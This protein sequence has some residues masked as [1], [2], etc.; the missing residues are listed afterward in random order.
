MNVIVIGG[1]PG[2]G[3]S[4]LVRNF[5]QTLG[6]SQEMVKWTLPELSRLGSVIGKEFASSRVIVLG[7]Y[8]DPEHRFPGTDRMSRS[9][10]PVIQAWFEAHKAR[11][12][13]Y[14]VIAEGQRTFTT[15]FVDMAVNMGARVTVV[16]VVA[17]PLEIQKRMRQR[18]IEL[19]NIAISSDK[20]K[21]AKGYSVDPLFLRICRATVRNMVARYP[22]LSEAWLNNTSDH[23]KANVL[24]LKSTVRL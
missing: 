19:A 21:D 5:M 17:G 20:G 1:E 14:T 8:S 15:K 22:N 3:K 13:T 2:A 18:K 9:V 12:A 7:N 11:L 16:E 24:R 10:Q 6:A 23:M 4:T